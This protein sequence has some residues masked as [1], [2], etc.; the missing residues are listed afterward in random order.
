MKCFHKEREDW[1]REKLTKMSLKTL[2]A[3]AI[4]VV[5]GPLKITYVKKDTS[6]RGAA[7]YKIIYNFHEGNP[8]NIK[9]TLLVLFLRH[10]VQ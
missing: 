8:V 2:M 5:Q 6:R 10:V 7:E 3:I 1:G 4:A 9:E